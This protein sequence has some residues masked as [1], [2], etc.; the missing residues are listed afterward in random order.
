MLG[1]HADVALVL[2]HIPSSHI[3]DVTES[4][5]RDLRKIST[6]HNLWDM[7]LNP[8]NTQST[9][10]NSS[11]AILLPN[12]GL[13]K[14]NSS[15]STCESFKILGVTFDSKS[16]FEKHIHSIY[17]SVAQKIGLLRKSF[18]IFGDQDVLLRCFNSFFLP[19]LEH[20]SPVWSYVADPI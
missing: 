19:S 17:A 15:L 18:R 9:I 4:L 2:V 6:W 1:S 14:S 12:P 10:A 16:T 8:N 3:S 11:R 5:N 7:K 13:L 20:C